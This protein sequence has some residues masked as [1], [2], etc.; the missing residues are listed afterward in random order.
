MMSLFKRLF[1][2]AARV[3]IN[4]VT[5]LERQRFAKTMTGESAVHEAVRLGCIAG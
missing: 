4:A 5:K 1:G 3:E 2:A